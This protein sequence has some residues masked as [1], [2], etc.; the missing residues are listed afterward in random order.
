M[1]FKSK[2]NSPSEEQ[3]FEIIELAIDDLETLTRAFHVI[4]DVCEE[5][6]SP[7]LEFAEAGCK[8]VIH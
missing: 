7:R 3:V 8:A 5:L 2:N 1:S 6:N 4:S